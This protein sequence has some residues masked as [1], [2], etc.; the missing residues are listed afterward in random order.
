ML[1]MRRLGPL[2]AAGGAM[3]GAAYLCWPAEPPK[4]LTPGRP[5]VCPVQSKQWVSSEAV[6]LRFELPSPTAT[7]GLPVPGHIMVVDAATNYRPYSPVSLE[8]PGYFELL[9]RKYP[10]GEFSTQLARLEPGDSATFYGPVESRYRYE[11]GATK[12]LGLVAAGTGITPMWQMIQTALADPK[13]T[14]KITLVYASTSPDRI[15][16]KEELDQAAA[17]HPDRFR[18]CYVVSR[19]GKTSQSLEGAISGM[20]LGRI[21]EELLRAELPPAPDPTNDEQTSCHIVVSGPET[22]LR[23]LCGPRARDG[24]VHDQP[25][26]NY[27]DERRPRHP[28][29]GGV[30]RQLGYRS[31]QVTWL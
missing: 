9:V 20:R 21:N 6:R 1:S 19:Q 11:R 30:L 13:D 24:G 29:I 14:T 2:A 26:I 22:M 31:N 4:T 17:A 5:L 12:E 10:G 7:L 25:G 3:A 15:L 27:P 23:E 18:A 8:T 28:A 16:L